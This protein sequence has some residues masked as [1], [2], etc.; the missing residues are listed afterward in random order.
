MRK[1]S[2]MKAPKKECIGAVK[3][4]PA[5]K[6]EDLSDAA[7]PA[8]HRIIAYQI[9]E[10]DFAPIRPG[11]R[12]RRWMDNANGRF[13]YRSLP[14]VIA[15]QYGWE[16]LSTRQRRSRWYGTWKPGSLYFG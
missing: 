10:H 13:P 3:T 12:E 15:N 6:T 8:D 7:T 14:L 2:V 4:P 9:Y 11:P 1:P 16:I 5:R